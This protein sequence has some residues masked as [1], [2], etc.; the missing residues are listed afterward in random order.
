MNIVLCGFMGSGKTT[1]GR[2]L[3]R[4]SGY[5]FVD[6]DHYI[7]REQGKKIPEIFKEYGEPEF[8]RMETL[9]CK[10]LGR[11]DRRIIA[12]G[13][14]ALLKEEN[15]SYLK[16]NGTVFFLDPPFP[17]ILSRLRASRVPRPVIQGRSDEEI[18]EIYRARIGKYAALCDVQMTLSAP[19]QEFALEILHKAG[20]R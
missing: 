18:Y 7:E 17:A 3:A 4:Y 1:I 9:A 19:P 14:G 10:E 8:R 12:T 15:A 13:G 11:G 16:A 5:E 6:M 2:V 20:L